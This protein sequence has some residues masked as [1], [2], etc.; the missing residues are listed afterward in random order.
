MKTNNIVS[1]LLAFIIGI[2]VFFVGINA[3]TEE[4]PN[5]V[6]KVYLNGETL[7]V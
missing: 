2:F 5:R 3:N 4:L 7:G 6:Y 1:I